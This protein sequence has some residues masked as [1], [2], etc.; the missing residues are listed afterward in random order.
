MSILRILPLL[1]GLTATAAAAAPASG[2]FEY[3][4]TSTRAN[5]AMKIAVSGKNVRSDMDVTATGMGAM[6]MSM[7]MKG[8]KAFML[9]AKDKQYSELDLSEHKP[10]R[11]DQKFTVKKVGPEKVGQWSALHVVVTDERGDTTD[12]WVT[13]DIDIGRSIFELLGQRQGGDD[14]VTKA[15]VAAGAD[16]FP[17]KIVSTKSGSTMEL[18]SHNKSAPAAALFDIPADWKKADAASV[19]AGSLPP[20]ARRQMEEAMK[21]LTPEQRKMMEEAMKS[22]QR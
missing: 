18:V 20:E 10:A 9:N 12:M 22:Q 19:A 15:L 11:N 5:G 1:L 16:G 4:I 14:G 8:D 2:T 17:V 3:K 21:K 7:L 13:K 6:Q